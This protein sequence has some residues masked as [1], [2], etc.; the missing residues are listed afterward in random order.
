MAKVLEILS[1]SKVHIHETKV[2]TKSLAE[3]A[4]RSERVK[5]IFIS[6]DP[7]RDSLSSIASY[8]S[9]FH[10][11]FVGL[12]GTHQQI[13]RV[14]K[15]YRMYYSAPPRAVDDDDSDYLV[16]HSI[17]FYLVNPEGNY[18]AHF[19]RQETAESVAERIISIMSQKN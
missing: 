5:P 2:F 12:T 7:K 4:G 13:K 17:F 1:K 14:A 6:C 16:D 8:L 9:D 10:P 3:K 18:V 19:G 11:D 15:A